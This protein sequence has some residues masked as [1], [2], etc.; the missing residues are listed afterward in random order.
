ML[1]CS[2]AK[3]NDLSDLTHLFYQYH[4]FHNI[5]TALPSIKNF[6]HDRFLFNDS[7]IYVIKKNKK[8]YGFS[9]IYSSYSS[10]AMK[11]IWMINDLFITHSER[12]Q[13]YARLLMHYIYNEAKQYHV[14]SLKLATHK[15][16]NKAKS[17]YHSLNYQ[18]NAHFDYYSQLV[19]S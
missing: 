1:E 9:Q 15:T 3:M 5:Q 4:L 7:I 11:P 13:G 8:I 2:R 10:I 16:N 14:F 12:K 17:L 6:L 18:K 19:C